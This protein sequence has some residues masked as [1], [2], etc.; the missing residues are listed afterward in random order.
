MFDKSLTY[1]KSAKGTEAMAQRSPALTPKMRSMLILVDGKRGYADLAKLGGLLGDADQVLTQL[2]EHGFIEPLAGSAPAR[3]AGAA[4]AAPAA[5]AASGAAPVQT[6]PLA[7]AKRFAV[8][9]LT[10]MLGPVA[11]DICMRIEGTRNA[12]DFMAAIQ[13]AENMLRQVGSAQ[14]A[15]RFAAEMATRRPQ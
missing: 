5:P 8:R 7:D 12:Q 9:L 14:K 15:A 6:V 3:P 2:A 10:D 1:S 13:K 4:T 11:D